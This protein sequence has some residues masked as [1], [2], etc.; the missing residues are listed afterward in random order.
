MP[1]STVL[2]LNGAQT[3]SLSSLVDRLAC[4][5]HGWDNE[6]TDSRR[7]AIQWILSHTR[8]RDKSKISAARSALE[9]AKSAFEQ[10]DF[11]GADDFASQCSKVL[12]TFPDT[13]T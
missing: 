2:S 5:M 8:T 7:E 9:E 11:T 1:S 4:H 6:Q 3:A 10:S 13:K 12:E